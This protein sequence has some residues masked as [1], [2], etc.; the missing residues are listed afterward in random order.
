MRRRYHAIAVT[1]FLV[2]CSDAPGPSVAQTPPQP[3]TTPDPAIR[4]KTE[5]FVARDGVVIVKCWGSPTKL[6]GQ[7]GSS[8]EVEPREFI[9]ASTGKRE[10]GITVKVKESSRL[11]RDDTAYVDFDEIDSLL[12]GLDYIVKVDKSVT[13]LESFEASYKTRG[14]FMV[15]TYT[16]EGRTGAAVS[17]GRIGPVDAFLDLPT[18]AKFRDAV[19]SAKQRLDAIRHP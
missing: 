18:L 14:D 5:A 9:D 6:V 4:T 10:Y 16:G 12:K 17:S 7:Y 2:A 8:V 13:Q 3:P 19:A 15:T 11:E 1:L